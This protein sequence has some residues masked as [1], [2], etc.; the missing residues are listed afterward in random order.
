MDDPARQGWRF[1]L[2]RGFA[3][4]LHLAAVVAQLILVVGFPPSLQS[5]Q[6]TVCKTLQSRPTRR[7]PHAGDEPYAADVPITGDQNFDRKLWTKPFD[8]LA[9]ELALVFMW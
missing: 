9:N 5:L 3:G 2:S 7:S 6:G 8:A 4:A 1:S